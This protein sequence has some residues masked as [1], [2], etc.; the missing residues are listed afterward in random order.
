MKIGILGGGQLGRMLA[1]A[2]APLGIECRLLDPAAN[3]C[4]GQVAEL[5]V[6][7]YTDTATLDRFAE[8]CDAITYEFENIPVSAVDHLAKRWPLAPNVT[9][10]A[11][12]QDRLFEKHLCTKL[13][14]PTTRYRDIATPADLDAAI[15]E[16]GYPAMLKTRR[17]GYDGK[18][19]M[20]LRSEADLAAA[21][22]MAT[23]PLLLEERI[24]FQ[25]EFS[26]VA[27]RGQDGTIVTY[28]LT[29]NVHR[30]GILWISRSPAPS[31]TPD[32]QA[33]ADRLVRT[34]LEHLQYVGV[35]AV[36]LFCRDGQLLVN[37]L[38]PRVHNSGHWT[39]NGCRVSQFENHMRAVAGLPVID[40]GATGCSAM[41]NVL[42]RVPDLS[43][44]FATPGVHVHLYGKKK[45]TRKLGHI[46]VVAN[47]P[48]ACETLIRTVECVLD[49]A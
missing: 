15:A 24:A 31:A 27:C 6:G 47:T 8:G 7:N 22:D 21:R 48:A 45:Q 33:Q 34:I 23:V 13:G 32:L 11:T 25:C 14:V 42:D 1:L 17:L 41:I 44:L 46:N 30:D 5:H 40:P 10:L 28:P 36:E 26:I 38:A 12:A 43:Q 2:G 16:I 4:G 35:L 3:A 39:Q 9:A 29:E 19:Q 49:A 20:T 18:G 37:E